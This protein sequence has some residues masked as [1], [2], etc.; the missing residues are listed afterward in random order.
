MLKIIHAKNGFTM[1]E[2]LVCIVL[3]SFGLL[4]LLPM[5]TL[6]MRGNDTARDSSE[7]SMLIRDKMEELKNASNPISGADTLGAMARAWTVTAAG[8][9]LRRLQVQATWTDR[10][11][12][13]RSN[14]IVTYMMTN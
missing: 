11:G 3:L 7:A 1:V 10:D 4:M 12:L 13:A 2:V 9:N 5:M 6:S 8:V 14:R